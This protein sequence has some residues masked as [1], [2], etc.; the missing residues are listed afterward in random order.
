M[1]AMRD[2]HV[3][4]GEGGLNGRGMVVARNRV[5]CMARVEARFRVV[6]RAR[7]ETTLH[8]GHSLTSVLDVMAVPWLLKG[9]GL[10]CPRAIIC[11]R[12]CTG[13]LHHPFTRL[14]A[15]ETLKGI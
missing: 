15:E 3:K 14:R 6:A 8:V 4:G 7:V 5:E 1:K 2:V 10:Y 12:G 13:L 11:F 9:M